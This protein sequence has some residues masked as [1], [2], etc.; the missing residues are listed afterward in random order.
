K[1]KPYTPPTTDVFADFERRLSS[2]I[3]YTLSRKIVEEAFGEVGLLPEGE[4]QAQYT[5][6][7]FSVDITTDLAQITVTLT[8]IL[9]GNTTS[10]EV[11]YF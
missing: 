3:L 6:G 7:T 10:I 4:T 11:P 2:Q 8:D 1:P 9:T 5:I